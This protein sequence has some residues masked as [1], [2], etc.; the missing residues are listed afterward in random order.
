M[1]MTPDATRAASGDVNGA[2]VLWDL[3]P[4]NWKAVA[5]RIAGRDHTEDEHTRYLGNQSAG[6]PCTDNE[7]ES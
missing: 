3:D 7:R 5:C 4:R 6:D 1:G 2:V